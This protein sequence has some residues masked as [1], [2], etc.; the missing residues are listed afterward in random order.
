MNEDGSINVLDVCTG[1]GAG[2]LPGAY[3]LKPRWRT[4]CAIEWEESPASLLVQRQRE[5]ALEPFPI[6]RDATQFDGRP[7]AGVVDLVAGGP[8]C[9]SYSVAG[10]GLAEDDPRDLLPT[11]LRILEE[12]AAPRFFLENVRNLVA[13]DA[14]GQML[15]KL[16]E[17]GFNVEWSTLSTATVG[18][19]HKRDRVWVY[20]WR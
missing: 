19:N 1:G 18:G 8:P 16:G 6:F 17:L 2:T 13:H 11:F 9:Q 3:L 5:Q 4:V 10:K 12:C 20:G 15:G 14:F 7:W